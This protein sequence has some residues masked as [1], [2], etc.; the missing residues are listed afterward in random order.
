MARSMYLINPRPSVPGYNS[1]WAFERFGLAPATLMGDLALPTVA[2]LAPPELEVA[3]CDEA[4]Q[5]FDPEHPADVIGLTGKVS[6]F[7]RARELAAHFRARGKTVV[8]GGPFASL[9]PARAR[10]HC[11][12]LVRGELEPIAERFFADLLADRL[13]PEYEG[14]PAD[15]QRRVVPRWDLYG[16]AQRAVMATVQT[17]RGCPF[18]CEFCDVIVYLGRKQRH[19]PPADVLAE[20]DALYAQGYR[21]VFLADDNLTVHRRAARALLAA[22]CDWNADRPDGRVIFSTQLSIDVTR[23]PDLLDLCAQAGIQIA[24][25]GIESVNLESLRETKKR[26]NLIDMIAAVETITRAGVSVAAGLIVGFDH[27]GPDIFERQFEFAQASP[28]PHFAFG[29]LTAPE[30]TPLYARLAAE[31]RLVESDSEE[32]SQAQ[33]LGTNIVPARMSR[34]ELQLGARWLANK[35]YDPENYGRRVLRMVELLAED[36]NADRMVRTGGQRSMREVDEDATQLLLRLP[37]L[38]PRERRMFIELMAAA[39]RKPIAQPFVASYLTLYLNT[40]TVYDRTGVW[41][42][43]LAAGPCPVG[44]G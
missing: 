5:T 1:G 28:I 21:Q 15:L 33:P 25:V 37:D 38:G 7:P 35:I 23:D 40:R 18:E 14:A 44:A 43:D 6:Q 36:R 22:L 19:K 32:E 39:R 30:A 34:A 10:E 24:L 11:D 17:S 26:Q 4:W 31:G 12:V 8:M 9:S 20:L 27:D 29:I 42:P 16:P 3:L 13:E 2:A 41:D